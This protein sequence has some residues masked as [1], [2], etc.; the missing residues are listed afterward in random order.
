LTTETVKKPRVKKAKS[1]EE[2]ATVAPATEFADTV[3][4]EEI[5]APD[6][7]PFANDVPE[8]EDP[9]PEPGEPSPAEE[10]KQRVRDILTG[11][12]SGKVRNNHKYDHAKARKRRRIS[13][14]SRRRNRGR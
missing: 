10:A 9:E 7:D 2:L 14:A 12:P 8:D 4:A 5:D 13:E 6:Y 3:T 11:S 1:I